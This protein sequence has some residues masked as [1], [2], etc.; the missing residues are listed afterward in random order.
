M[1]IDFLLT[2][3]IQQELITLLT[4]FW[5][6]RHDYPSWFIDI[7]G[8]HEKAFLARHRMSY[9]STTIESHEDSSGIQETTPPAPIRWGFHWPSIMFQFDVL[10]NLG[11]VQGSYSYLMEGDVPQVLS[12]IEP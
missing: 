1:S 6:A 4:G 9:N 12:T 8:L 11:L 2:F 7:D 3:W 10:L 5:H